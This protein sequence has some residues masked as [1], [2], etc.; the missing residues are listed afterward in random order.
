MK[1]FEG[2]ARRREITVEQLM[3]AAIIGAIQ[4]RIEGGR[5]HGRG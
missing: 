3:A 4:D 2:E 5:R 1:R